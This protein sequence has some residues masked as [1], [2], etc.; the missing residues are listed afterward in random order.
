[1][2][3]RYAAIA[4]AGAFAIAT[5]ANADIVKVEDMLRGITSSASKCAATQQAVWVS[6]K[7]REFCMRYY[8]SNIGESRRPIVFLQG[9]RLGVLD[10]RTG[11][12]AVLPGEKDINTDDLMRSATA[13][14]RATK[15]PAIYLGRVGLEGSSGDHRIRHTLLELHATNAALDAIK[16]KHNFEGFHL[17][18]QSGGAHLVAGLLSMRQD[19]GCTVIGSGPLSPDKRARLSSDPLMERFNPSDMRAAIILNRSA[20]IMVVTD[21]ADKKVDAHMQTSFVRVLQSGGRPAEQY[22]VQAIDD[23]RHG[24]VSYSRVVLSGCL[25]NANS[26]EIAQDVNQLVQRAATIK[27][28]DGRGSSGKDA[29]ASSPSNQTS[30]GSTIQVLTPPKLPAARDQA[31]PQNSTHRENTHG[32]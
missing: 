31:S 28:S 21:P 1:M 22:I 8:F 30:G 24:V 3:A 29:A 10:L 15:T 14:S 19:L 17:M 9:D 7:G 6:A 18:G 32:N 5:P 23:N 20:R 13:L 2:S 11:N 16:Q 25:R 26:S 27:P 12:F 4:L